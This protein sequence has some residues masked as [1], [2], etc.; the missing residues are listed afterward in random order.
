MAMRLFARSVPCSL[1]P[2]LPAFLLAI[3]TQRS[4][5]EQSYAQIHDM[6]EVAPS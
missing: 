5:L 3:H 4:L 2:S 6:P 1:A